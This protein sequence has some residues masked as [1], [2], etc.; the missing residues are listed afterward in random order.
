MLNR[1][2]WAITCITVLTS[3]FTKYRFKYVVC[4][5]SKG[6]GTC[7]KL[8]R[9]R[10]TSS[11]GIKR[12]ARW[13]DG[14]HFRFFNGRRDDKSSAMSGHTPYSSQSVESAKRK[15]KLPFVHLC[16][17]RASY[18]SRSLSCRS[19]LRKTNSLQNRS[20][21]LVPM[22]VR[23][24]VSE[25]GTPLTGIHQYNMILGDSLESKTLLLLSFYNCVETDDAGDIDLNIQF[26]TRTINP[27]ET[28]ISSTWNWRVLLASSSMPI[29]ISKIKSAYL[30]TFN[31]RKRK[32][33]A[34]MQLIEIV[35]LAATDK[36]LAAHS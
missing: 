22:G 32:P 16:R 28:R 13:L 36:I 18:M 5:E 34:R 20:P 31:E 27:A 3:Q 9:C 7:S 35:K 8:K 21:P 26:S 33:N 1:Y 10:S 24:R 23:A 2:E 4:V 17:L 25:V 12:S 14:C 29:C 30:L 6:W 11:D 15:S 19:S